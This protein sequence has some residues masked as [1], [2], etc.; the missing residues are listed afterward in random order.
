M[1]PW[2]YISCSPSATDSVTRATD[3]YDTRL[4]GTGDPIIGQKSGGV[5]SYAGTLGRVVG[6]AELYEDI[7]LQRNV[8]HG[9]QKFSTETG[10]IVGLIFAAQDVN[11]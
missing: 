5:T 4:K 10:N 3:S 1:T 11:R 2:V 9:V 7:L 8:S 6:R